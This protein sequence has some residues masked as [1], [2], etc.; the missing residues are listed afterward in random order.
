[1]AKVSI[2][3]SSDIPQKVKGLIQKTVEGLWEASRVG[4]DIIGNESEKECPLDISTLKDSWRV[5]P[6]GNEI[7]FEFGYY[8]PYAS[9]LHEHPEYHFQNGRK[10]KYLEH[11]IEQNLGDWQGQ[12]V[13]KLKQI[14]F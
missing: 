3:W 13:N 8:T 2:E 6:L 5:T 7:G 9:R 14:L 11:P 1:M 4:V 10:A 12:T